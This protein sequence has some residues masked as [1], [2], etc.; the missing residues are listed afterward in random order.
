MLQRLHVIGGLIYMN[1]ITN[2]LQS[3]NSIVGY[4]TGGDGGIQASVN[5]ILA[6]SEA[7]ASMVIIGVPFSDPVAEGP[8]IQKASM[9]ALDSG[10]TTKDMFVIV[11]E[12]RKQ[13]KIPLILQTYANPVYIY[14][15]DAFFKQCQESGVDGLII[16]DIPFEECDEISLYCKQYDVTQIFMVSSSS[17]KRITDIVSKASGC[18]YVVGHDISSTIQQVRE[19]S[20]IPV[21]IGYN[22]QNQVSSNHVNG[23]VIDTPIVEICEKHEKDMDKQIFAYI[24]KRVVSK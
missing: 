6:L 11:N 2:A 15:Y 10:I 18:L 1:K 5:H 21:I 12:V 3:K 4:I 14:G 17:D 23:I 7:G 9:R 13:S 8:V 19:V 20:E 22:D 24:Q 16:P